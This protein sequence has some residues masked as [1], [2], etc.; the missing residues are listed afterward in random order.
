MIEKAM[1]MPQISGYGNTMEHER[2]GPHLLHQR[3]NQGGMADV[4]IAY[5]AENRPIAIRRLRPSFKLNFFKRNEFTR[6]LGVQAHLHHPNVV[7]VIKLAKLEAVPYAVMEYVDGT[8]LRQVMAR[9]DAIL[10]EPLPLMEQMIAGL[11]HIHQKGYMHLDF[12]PENIMI[13]H[14]GEVKILDFDLAQKILKHPVAQSELKGTPAYLSP[15]QILR[16]PVDERADIFALG[17]TLHELFTGKKPVNTGERRDIF[18][19]YTDLTHP[20]PSTRTITPSIPLK[21]DRL[22]LNCL[23]KRVDHRYPTL[24]MVARDFEQSVIATTG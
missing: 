2:C 19:F 9:R 5:N 15:E 6:G 16:Q 12:K 23:E 4:Y 20:F 11:S 3:L 24:A 21:L 22:I 14:R 17:V 18:R 7:R 8:N 13:S 1:S 10:N